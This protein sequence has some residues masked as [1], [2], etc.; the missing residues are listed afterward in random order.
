MFCTAQPTALAV[1][2]VELEHG[3]AN[4]LDRYHDLVNR[5]LRKR[6][7]A[8]ISKGRLA[9]ILLGHALM[10]SSKDVSAISLSWMLRARR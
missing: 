4:L 5:D 6:G 9:G 8:P 1:D 3:S 10:C 7:W 2:G